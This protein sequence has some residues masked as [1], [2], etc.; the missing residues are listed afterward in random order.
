MA[1]ITLKVIDYSQYISL[2]YEYHFSLGN[3]Q[4]IY[5]ILQMRDNKNHIHREKLHRIVPGK[6]RIASYCPRE[7]LY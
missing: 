3:M 5:L 1:N 2:F 4:G 7:K 6:N